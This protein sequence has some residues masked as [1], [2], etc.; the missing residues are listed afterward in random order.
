MAARIAIHHV[1]VCFIFSFRKCKSADTI[2][3]INQL[4]NYLKKS[5]PLLNTKLCKGSLQVVKHANG[6]NWW[7]YMSDYNAD[8]T[9]RFLLHDGNLTGPFIQHFP[10]KIYEPAPFAQNRQD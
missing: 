5:I 8:T 9:F 6:H 2:F 7:I 3:A 4:F 1:I 10:F